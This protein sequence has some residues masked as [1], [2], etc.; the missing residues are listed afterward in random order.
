MSKKKPSKKNTSQQL[1]KKKLKMKYRFS[2]IL[3]SIWIAVGI[4][5]V[6]LLIESIKI[7]L[8]I[9]KYFP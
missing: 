9:K 2:Y 1:K 5:M 6:W 3:T 8:A 7:I 4:L